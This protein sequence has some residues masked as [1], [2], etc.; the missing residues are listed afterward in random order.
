MNSQK[1]VQQPLKSRRGATEAAV[2]PELLKREKKK[3]HHTDF[4]N[5]D[6][7][8]CLESD[9]FSALEIINLVI[10]LDHNKGVVY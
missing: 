4:F 6:C 9:L 2:N 5:H 8:V 7:A 3:L 1:V 10:I